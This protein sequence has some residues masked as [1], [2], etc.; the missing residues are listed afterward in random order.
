MK[1]KIKQLLTKKWSFDFFERLSKIISDFSITEKVV[2][3]L[4]CGVFL[5]SGAVIANKVSKSF[6]LSVPAN[7]GYLREG[8]IGTPRFINP[9]L[10]VSDVDRDLTSLIYSG[11]LKGSLDNSLLPNLAESYEI[12]SDGLE[13]TFI[14]RN[15]AYFQDGKKVTVD[16]VIF[17]INKIQLFLL[18]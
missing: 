15:D 16:D 9:V 18:Y 7:G 13:Y 14:L 12:S 17:T 1:E 3:Y 4:L 6:T 8:I 10:A 11:L 5:V 2:F